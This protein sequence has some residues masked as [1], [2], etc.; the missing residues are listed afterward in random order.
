MSTQAIHAR[1]MAEFEKRL[2]SLY[3]QSAAGIEPSEKERDLFD[4][5]M[6]AGLVT[7]LVTQSELQ[8]FIDERHHS[9]FGMSIAERRNIRK[10]HHGLDFDEADYSTYDVP[11]WLRKGVH[12]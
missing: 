4:G 8:A 2:L 5:Y 9:V 1:Y 7:G 11:A 6:D 3:R 12:L 10:K